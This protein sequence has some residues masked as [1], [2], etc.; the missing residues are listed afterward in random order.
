M[1]KDKLFEEENNLSINEKIKKDQQKRMVHIILV[2]SLFSLVLLSLAAFMISQMISQKEEFREEGI[3]AY[4]ASSY[5]E[6]ENDFLKSLDEKQWFSENMDLDTKLYLASAYMRNGEFENAS[7]VY[8]ELQKST[9]S[10]LKSYDLITMKG[11][12]DALLACQT[13]Q[14]YTS[15]IE[16]LKKESERGN[17]T[18]D[19]YLGT[20]Y[21]QTGDEENMVTYYQK[22]LT[23]N[24]SGAG[25]SYINY[26]LSSYYLAKKDFATAKTY[27]D[28]GL[29]SGDQAYMD[30]IRFN[31]IVYYEGMLDFD[32][33]FSKAES[34]TNDMPENDTYKN[35]YDFLYTRTHIDETPVHTEGDAAQ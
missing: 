17:H 26:Q 8:A 12:A 35:E 27:I 11:L 3:K 28:A 16:D 14:D 10:Y 24:T 21:Q 23:E 15:Y 33:A 5:V 1:K 20:C 31:E 4:N 32:T 19:L 22:Y 29:A 2:L 9:N 7:H 34:L 18:A 13:G 30:L 25:S 6:A